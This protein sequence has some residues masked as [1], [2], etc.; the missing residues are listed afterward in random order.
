[1]VMFLDGTERRVKVI[2][3]RK[4][5][6]GWAVLLPLGCVGADRVGVVP[7]RRGADDGDRSRA[8]S[9]HMRSGRL[10]FDREESGKIFMALSRPYIP[11]MI[12]ACAAPR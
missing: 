8:H 4:D 1:M 12:M 2:G 6:G 7:V 11:L 5:P 9:G 10:V 3:W